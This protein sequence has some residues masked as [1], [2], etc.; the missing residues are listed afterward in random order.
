M[1]P[2]FLWHNVGYEFGIAGPDALKSYVPQLEL[3]E[4]GLS[5]H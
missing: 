3:V 5:P 2:P 4:A 1:I